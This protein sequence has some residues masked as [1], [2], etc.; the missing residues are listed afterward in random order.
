M[1][2][3]ANPPD[4]A[5]LL[6]ELS[7]ALSRHL[8][9]PPGAADAMALWVMVAHTHDAH[10]HSPRLGLPSPTMRCGKTTAMTA[11][12]HVLPNPASGRF[13]SAAIFRL[14]SQSKKAGRTPTLLLDEADTYI[15]GDG[16]EEFRGIINQ[17]H[18]RANAFT[19]RCDGENNREATA[20]LVWAPM[21]IAMIGELPDTVRDRSIVVRIKRKLPLDMVAPLNTAAKGHLTD[22]GQKAAQWGAENVAALQ[23]ADPAMPPALQ[24]NDRAQDNW[25]PLFAVADRAGGVWPDRARRAA[26]ALEGSAPRSSSVDGLALLADIHEVFGNHDAMSSA[27]LCAKLSSLEDRPWR[28]YSPRREGIM[29]N[30]VAELL[31]PYEVEPDRVRVGPDQR[32]ARGYRREWFTD[33]WARYGITTAPPPSPA[34][35]PSHAAEIIGFEPA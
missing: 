26:E 23:D 4:G 35:T 31:K 8:V 2:A 25:R 3:T 29:P 27:D 32:Q 1:T 16:A 15:R 24:S 22:L 19:W 30:Q 10:R 9:L 18:E 20:H 17:G 33:P 12:R 28:T 21:A 11:L 14:I 34:V 6:D 5:N 7:V 13:S